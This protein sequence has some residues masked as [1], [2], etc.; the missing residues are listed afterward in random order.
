VFLSEILF[1]LTGIIW[2]HVDQMSE[3]YVSRD[4]QIAQRVLDFY[5]TML[6]GGLDGN[7]AMY[8]TNN[9]MTII[10]SMHE[11]EEGDMAYDNQREQPGN[12]GEN[13]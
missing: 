6:A 9:Y 13:L 10:T 4:A 12:L 5:H 7:V 1:A 3:Y 11:V 8:L 2:Y